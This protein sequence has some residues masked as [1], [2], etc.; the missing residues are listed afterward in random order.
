MASS[1]ISVSDTSGTDDGD[2]AG[3][4]VT[5]GSA[6]Q[7][8]DRALEVLEIVARLGTAGVTAIADEL[9]V[10]KSTVSRL[11]GVLDARGF[12]EQVG[13][14][15]KY[16]LG[17]TIV[18][19]AGSATAERDLAKAAQGICDLLAEKVGE[20]TNVAVLDEDRAVN[21]VK[22]RSE[23]E[24]AL[25]TWVGQGSPVH[26]TSSGKILL[27]GLPRDEVRRRLPSRLDS[28]TETTVTSLTALEQELEA[29]RSR[30]WASVREE[31]E[32]GLNAVSA[33]VRDHTG[34]VVAALSV[35]GPAYRLESDD[36]AS[37]AA[38]AMSAA[39]EISRRLGYG[40][41]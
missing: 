28:F 25:R 4:A 41:D 20:T 21:I 12:V 17:F 10:H 40:G 15:G 27:S 7:S 24:V 23:S 35:S 11:L 18:R 26:A 2:D 36:F 6:V 32:I 37:V 5:R 1:E 22:A 30:G 9:G 19:L 38:D 16:R 8:V 13:E 29:V 34:D 31:L 14:R 33:P 3:R 39:L